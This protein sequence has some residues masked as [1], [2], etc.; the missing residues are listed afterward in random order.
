MKQRLGN[1][2]SDKTLSF[3]ACECFEWFG[4]FRKSRSF[5]TTVKISGGRLRL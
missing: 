1:E 3:T 5:A 2:Q 4:S